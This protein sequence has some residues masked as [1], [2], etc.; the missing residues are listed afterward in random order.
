[1]FKPEFIKK[2]KPKAEDENYQKEVIS[3]IHEN[4][5]NLAMGRKFDLSLGK[6]LDEGKEIIEILNNIGKKDLIP[7]LQEYKK[8]TDKVSLDK[9][10][11]DKLLISLQKSKNYQ[12]QM[13]ELGLILDKLKVRLNMD[14]IQDILR[15]D[16][17]EKESSELG[18]KM[19]EMERQTLIFSTALGDVK[20]ILFQQL[21]K[22]N[23]IP[24]ELDQWAK[25]EER[26][27]LK[28][29]KFEFGNISQALMLEILKLSNKEEEYQNLK[30]QKQKEIWQKLE[31][32]NNEIEAAKKNNNKPVDFFDQQTLVFLRAIFTSRFNKLM[33]KQEYREKL[34]REYF[35][36]YFI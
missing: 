4:I 13:I 23:I 9:L 32:L 22:K 2:E 28:K 19:K 1:M 14:I 18:A 31:M 12:P 27:E 16:F 7:F 33:A 8:K 5:K 25:K 26:N 20:G 36:N 3:L 30:P 21:L 11:D 34:E 29:A 6:L 15:R 17:I 10:P 35:E 24:D